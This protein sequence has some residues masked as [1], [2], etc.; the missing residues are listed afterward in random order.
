M[1]NPFKLVP[2]LETQRSDSRQ[3]K[4]PI[5]YC[6]TARRFNQNPSRK[7]SKRSSDQGGP[8][9]EQIKNHLMT[10]LCGF[11]KDLGV[12]F[13]SRERNRALD[14][15]PTT[16]M[17]RSQLDLSTERTVLC[18]QLCGRSCIFFSADSKLPSDCCTYENLCGG[19]NCD[20]GVGEMAAVLLGSGYCH[21][22]DEEGMLGLFVCRITSP[23]IGR[24]FFFSFFAIYFVEK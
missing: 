20:K 14:P 8:I 12:G 13:L 11:F 2:N 19:V 18:G 4:I 24:I 17:K 6:K 10:I 22:G 7:R 9:Y 16:D 15:E 23:V 21:P 3:G 1:V 5:S